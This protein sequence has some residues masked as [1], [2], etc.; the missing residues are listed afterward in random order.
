M[1]N[2]YIVKCGS[3]FD[4]IKNQFNDFEHWILDKLENKNRLVNI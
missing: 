4:S 3:T 1:K 2:L